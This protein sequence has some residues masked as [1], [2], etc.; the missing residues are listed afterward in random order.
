[1]LTL[2]VILLGLVVAMLLGTLYHSIRGG[3][4]WRLLFFLGL[5]ILGFTFGHYLG[6]WLS[7]NFLLIGSLNLG[8]AI[9]GSILF[10]VG[11]E[12]LSRI[13]VKNKSSV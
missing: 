5:S 13:E 8:M 3:G 4:G 10:L 12:W 1:M 7:W 6:T 9:P 11:G 2:P